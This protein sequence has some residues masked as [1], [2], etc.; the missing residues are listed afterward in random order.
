MPTLLTDLPNEVIFQIFLHVPSSSAHALQRVSRRFKDV[1]NPL[2]W[3]HHCQTQYRYWGGQHR[4]QEKYAD[5]AAK[6]D[7]KNIFL[8]RHVVDKDVNQLLDKML[9]SQEGRIEKSEKIVGLGYDAKDALLRNLNV[10]ENA[11]DVLA[12]R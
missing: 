4:I 6:I 8:K 9:A 3:K 2:L 1:A 10:N 5:K 7:W 11:P 12:R